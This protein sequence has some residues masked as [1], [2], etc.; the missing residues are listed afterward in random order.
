MI[1][2]PEMPGWPRNTLVVPDLRSINVDVRN[3]QEHEMHA[4]YL[5][6]VEPNDDE[7]RKEKG[8]EHID[9][10]KYNKKK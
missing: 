9:A 8:V 6:V 5:E 3:K 2:K 4:G 10:Q 1:F 7:W